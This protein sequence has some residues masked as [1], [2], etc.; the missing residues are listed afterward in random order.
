MEKRE[1]IVKLKNCVGTSWDVFKREKQNEILVLVNELA[2]LN[3]KEKLSVA[4]FEIL[5]KTFE[6]VEKAV[7]KGFVF[8]TLA[9]LDDNKDNF[10][11]KEYECFVDKVKTSIK[12]FN[13]YLWGDKGNG[14]SHFCK[15][16]AAT[17]GREII[18]Q[19][20]AIT[21]LDFQGVK[22]IQGRYTYSL[23]EQAFLGGKNK[24]GAVLVL[25]EMDSYSASALIYLNS[26][27]EQGYITTLEGEII[28]RH[29][30]TIV[31]ACGNTDLLT[32]SM[33]YSE[34]NVI[35]TATADRFLRIKMPNF[36][37]LNKL[38][39]GE[40]Y[41]RIN[42]KIEEKH[43]T[44]SVRNFI[45]LKKIIELGLDLNEFAETILEN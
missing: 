5:V 14:K 36:E 22:D 27:L 16:M 13:V 9:E 29:P 25:E 38:V 33:A 15:T 18:V 28:N 39:S 34:R 26:V 21:G 8:E 20:F 4:D 31:L 44:K 43:A 40:H 11:K 24:K 17:T 37:Y 23:L 32:P 7:A 2:D 30:N 19:N 10:L 3:T 45:R 41:E 12:G 6:K 42:S 1:F 35:D